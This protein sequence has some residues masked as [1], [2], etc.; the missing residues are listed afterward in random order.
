MVLGRITQQNDGYWV[1][2]E[3][4][5]VVHEEEGLSRNCKPPLQGRGQGRAVYGFSV[6]VGVGSSRRA[7]LHS[8][9]K[10]KIEMK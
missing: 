7:T 10:R 6:S 4:D 2:R 8:F 5:R 9:Q 3:A 1:G